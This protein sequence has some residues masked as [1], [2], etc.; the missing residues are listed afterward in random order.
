VTIK[1]GNQIYL[2]GAN[3]YTGGTTFDQTGIV[4][5]NSASSFGSSSGAFTMAV[6]GGALVNNTSSLIT[7]ANPWTAGT[8]NLNIVPGSGGTTFS[9][10]WTLGATTPI[11]GAGNVA[12]NVLTL[13]GIISGTTGGFTTYNSGTLVL[14]GANTY[15][16]TTT[17]GTT[18]NPGGVTRAGI[19]QNGTTSGP[20][21]KASAAGSIV[22]GGNFLQYSSANQTDYS[23]RF[24]TAASQAYKIDV[25]G[26]SVTFATVLSSSGGTLTLAD[27]A[28]GGKLTLS[29][30]NTYT[31]VTTLSGGTLNLN[32]SETASSN[33]PL[34]NSA[35]SNPGSIVLSGGTLQYSILNNNHDY[36]G[37]FSTA[38]NQKYNIDVNSRLVTFAT[39]LT[40]SGGVLTL[41]DTAGGG[42]LTL[43]AVNTYSGGT[44]I[45]SGATLTISAGSL[46]SGTYAG[47]I[48]NNG[49]FNYNSGAQTLSGIISGSGTLTKSTGT[50]TLTLSGTANTYSGITT[51][52]AGYVYISADAS[53][54]AAPGSP[55]ANQL[56]LNCGTLSAGL[57]FNANN[58][59]LNAYRGIYLAG[60][61]AGSGGS[62][63][64]AQNNTATI[65]GV[66]SGPGNFQ[67]GANDTTGTGTNVL[68]GLNTY[69][70]TTAIAAG[71]LKLGISGALPSGTPMTIAADNAGGS[72]FDLGGFSQTIGPL[73]SSTGI[74]SIPSPAGTPTIFLTGPLTI[75]ET[76]STTFAGQIVGAGGSLTLNGTATL[77]LSGVNTYTGPT[78]VANGAVLQ[79]DNNSALGSTASL[80]LNG[81]PSPGTIILNFSGT[82]QPMNAL[83]FGSTSMAQ[84][85]WGASGAQ[86]NN[87]AFTGSGLLQVN[88][89]GTATSTVL[90]PITPSPVCY[91]TTVNL[92][93]TVTGGSNGDGV[94]FF[95]G[96][97]SLG[98]APLSGGVATLPVSTLAA[99][100]HTSITAKYLGNL[101]AN[102]STSSAG[103]VTVNPAAATSAITGSGAVAIN[104][105]GQ[106]YSVTLTSGSSYAWGVPS[107]GSI[108]AGATGPNNN[109]ITVSFGSASGNVTVTET[110]S[111]SCVGTLVSLPVTVGPN[112]APVAPAPK[113]LT[114]AENTAATYVFAKLLDGAT[115]ADNDTLTVTAA[116]SPTAHGTTVLEASDVK[117]TPTTGYTGSDSYTYTISDGNGGTAVGTV[118]V[119]VTDNGGGSPNVVA[120][121]TFDSGTGTFSVTFAGIPGYEYTVEYAVGSA[122]PPWTKL[123]NV[124]A[125]SDGLFTVTDGPG[126]SGSRYY[127]TVY[128]SY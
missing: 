64:V 86:H 24:S 8:Y 30:A 23:P 7:F 100:A 77:E 13:S 88:S 92:T 31:G 124:I 49:T 56:T 91:G 102:Q 89:G 99:G 101:T 42:S 71:R 27:T 69:L 12:G 81:S 38:A 104:Q 96:V 115:D 52:N 47:A 93:A 34:G 106:T 76:S 15:S 22:F 28:G 120:G 39:A 72:F 48:V 122:A 61:G 9:G 80:T 46:G 57:R 45:N 29:G 68:S 36:S 53:L 19:A 66:I 79:L 117:Y 3:T 110:T 62:V 50:G 123:E 98:T 35:A 128:P 67:S 126:L 59:V 97:T 44:T 105:L 17:I 127:R 85:T 118:N 51:I 26:Q 54:G 119:T 74:G 73:A 95:D 70:G 90:S 25:N 41:S 103:S 116:G 82:P 18:T 114:T 37:R 20:F 11:I 78:T 60:S 121:P 113:S 40:S 84:G 111:A 21:G 112:H 109:Q 94:Q 14:S 58:I 107:G 125:G 33:G 75:N 87:P 65:A 83:Y 16:G 6:S 108:T 43:S 63:N 1:G 32:H 2:N 4:N 10:N 5:F 55:V